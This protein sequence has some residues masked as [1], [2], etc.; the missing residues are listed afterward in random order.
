MSIRFDSAD[1]DFVNVGQPSQLNLLPR[2]TEYT[3]SVW[4]KTKANTDSGT[5]ISRGDSASRQY[6][7]TFGSPG[8]PYELQAQIG[9]TFYSTG[10]KGADGVWHHCVLTNTNVAGT[11]RFQMYLD[12][13]AAG[14]SQPS[15]ATTIVCD[16][17]LGAR[18]ATGNTGSGFLLNGYLSDVR[19]YNRVLRLPEIQS[20]NAQRGHDSIFDGLVG[21]WKL[22][23]LAPGA[24][25]VKAID[26]TT[27]GANGT[28]SATPVYGEDVVNFRRR[29]T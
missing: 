1:S 10:V 23:E 19:V 6:Q 11:Y 22:N 25:V 18:R 14:T 17:L 12:G 16:T 2:G 4:A 24:A 28:P 9:G 8:P 7:F 27:Y 15:G 20:I 5:F 13:A 21:W 3:L 26:D 29:F